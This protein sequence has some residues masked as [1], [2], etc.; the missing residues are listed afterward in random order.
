MTGTQSDRTAVDATGRSTPNELFRKPLPTVIVIVLVVA[1]GLF[2]AAAVYRL[3]AAS[4]RNDADALGV[5]AAA[6]RK[7]AATGEQDARRLQRLLPDQ[8]ERTDDAAR[9]RRQAS[10]PA[11]QLNLAASAVAE[12]AA[13]L[14]AAHHRLIDAL[15][16]QN[17]DEFNA[18][19]DG[20]NEQL[21]AWYD[22][23]TAFDSAYGAYVSVAR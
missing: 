2:C 20:F 17:I 22:A 7:A 18:L 13:S 16:A 1:L 10:V 14:A 4:E 8:V 5:K 15:D 23:T 21:A 12:H 11:E 9:R 6:D 3:N 19:V